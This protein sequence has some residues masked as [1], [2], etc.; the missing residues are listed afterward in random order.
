[1]R[2]TCCDKKEPGTWG[3]SG[4]KQRYH[5]PPPEG[6]AELVNIVRKVREM[7]QRV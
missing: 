1:M 5:L 4:C 6:D 2:W 3:S 7:V